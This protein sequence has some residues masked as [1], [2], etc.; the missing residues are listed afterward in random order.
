MMP[1]QG[2]K[3]MQATLAEWW[4]LANIDM[5]TV[6][7]GPFDT[8]DDAEAEAERCMKVGIWA[9]RRLYPPAA[10]V[11]IDISEVTHSATKENR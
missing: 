9:E 2:N 1:K 10:I 11:Y 7:R 8:R 3:K 4:L 6:K 5:N